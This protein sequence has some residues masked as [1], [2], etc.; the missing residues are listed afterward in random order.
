L[1]FFFF[2]RKLFG[3][4]RAEKAGQAARVNGW[5]NEAISQAC[6]FSS[7]LLDLMIDVAMLCQRTKPTERRKEQI[8]TPLLP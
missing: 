7:P 5:R 1:D 4:A 3:N 2:T 6:T 8:S